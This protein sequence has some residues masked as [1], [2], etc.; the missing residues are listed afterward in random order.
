[1]GGRGAARVSVP[2]AIARGWG[3]MLGRHRGPASWA[4]S[5]VLGSNNSS[6]EMDIF[7]RVLD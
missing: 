3:R 5:V 4:V 1:M 6:S 2:V 7:E